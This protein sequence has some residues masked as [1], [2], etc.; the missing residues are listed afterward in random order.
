MRVRKLFNS[1][2]IL[3]FIIVALSFHFL[4][5][6]RAN[7]NAV[8]AGMPA[9]DIQLETL[10]GQKF[11]LYDFNISVML[12]FINT[13]TLLSSTIYPDLIL[14]RIPK[15]KLLADRNSAELIVLLDTDQNAEA[16]N[17]KLRSKKYKILENAVYLSN[18]KQAQEKYGLSS[19]PHFFLIDASHTVIY[20]AKVPS[21]DLLEAMLKGS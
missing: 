11:S 2:S 10:D 3:V 16:V 4:Y 9:P 8:P 17:D 12:V 14:K 1:K 5:R 18:I 21:T 7:V 6:Y 20:E 13:R 15:L 19:W